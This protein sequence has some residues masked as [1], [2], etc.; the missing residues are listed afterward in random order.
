MISDRTA[1]YG[2][3]PFV[4][5]RN[6][7]NGRYV[8]Q[9]THGN[10]L[11]GEKMKELE[12]PFDPQYILKKRRALKRA[13]IEQSGG[14]GLK[15]KIAVLG[16][17]TTDDIVSM[18]ELFLLN[19]GIEAEFW[20]SEYN[21]FWED[22]VFGN[23]ELEAFKPDIVYVC[24][25][26]VNLKFGSDPALT[27]QQADERI[28]A[29]EQKY[30]TLW[31]KLTRFGCPIIQNNFDAPF[32]ALMGNMDSWDKRGL[33]YAAHELNSRF[34]KH[35]RDGRILMLDLER[36]AA[37]YGLDRWHDR[38]YYYM[39]KYMCAREAVPSVAYKLSLIV[40]SIF[41][42]NRKL[43][44]L[45][46]DNTL[47]GGIVGDDGVEGL[48]IGQETGV[49]QAYYEFQQYARQL[50]SI[51]T[52]LTVCSKN[53]H[54]NA[55]AGLNHPE[56]V[57]RPDDF[58][59]IK[60]NW[61]PKDK[62]LL[63]TVGQLDLTPAAIVFA[64]DNPAERE[65]VR[66]TIPEASVPELTA[67]ED[68]IRTISRGGHFEP[69][70]ITA[71]DLARAE[72]YRRNAKRAELAASVGDYGEYLKSLEMRAE[73][74]PFK[75]MYIGRITQL[76]NKSNQFNL[77]TRR[78]TQAEME[79]FMESDKYITQYGKL[80]DKFGDN[81]VVS[82]I[83]GSILPNAKELFVDLW[84][85][86]CR[87]LKRDMELAMLDGLVAQA[88]AAGLTK[89]V[90]EYIPSPK[91]KMVER[92]YPDV[93]GFRLVIAEDDGCAKYELDISDYE[94]KNKYIKM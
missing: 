72:M 57:L 52:V 26:S 36:T 15:K 64:D 68:Y 9:K 29:E 73:I 85:M 20:Q 40:K 48:E 27:E 47:W 87:V 4:Q 5:I 92:F 31:E 66:Q 42:K 79:S 51:G 77:T 78:F 50:K 33:C 71:D 34:A 7:G 39:Y 3:S 93:L 35:A 74:A 62:N 83:V 81:G 49:A 55:I 86:S 67:P 23:D 1:A 89:I 13:L 16:G 32:Y 80:T 58:A 53:E 11:L 37:E 22:G 60:A 65:I 59:L 61:E 88:K 70:S 43:L 94:N 84:L 90:G 76:T 2:G 30:I 19:Y 28:D 6:F 56:G 38:S 82:V 91:N 41:G 18:A 44:A 75:P 17:S 8:K 46:L 12:Y 63:E 10:D 69:I 54:E 25:S 21:K 14:S 24:T 45:D